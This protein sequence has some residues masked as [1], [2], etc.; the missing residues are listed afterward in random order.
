MENYYDKFS[1]KEE[2]KGILAR[3]GR[4]ILVFAGAWVIFGCLFSFLQPIVYHSKIE[5]EGAQKALAN[6]QIELNLA[7][8]EVAKE[9]NNLNTEKS[10]LIKE[11]KALQDKLDSLNN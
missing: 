7:K 1:D 11:N 3:V 2:S 9:K 6:Y 10:N 4:Q 8:D 5:V